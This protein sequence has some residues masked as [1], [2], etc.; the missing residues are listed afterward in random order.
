MLNNKLEEQKTV[1]R[2]IS[3]FHLLTAQFS[4]SEFVNNKVTKHK[5]LTLV[6]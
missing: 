3:L 6:C 5:L 2:R 1:L 4:E